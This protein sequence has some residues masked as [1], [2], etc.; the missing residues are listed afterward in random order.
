MHG[1]IHCRDCGISEVPRRRLERWQIETGKLL[2]AVYVCADCAIH[3][4]VPGQL[5]QVGKATWAGRPRDVWFG[6]GN[7]ADDI[8]IAVETLPRRPKAIVFTPTEHGAGRWQDEID[9][10]VIALESALSFDGREFRLDIEHVESRIID[11]GLG[12]EEETPERKP[13]KRAE[14]AA[15]IERIKN[16]L[17]AH[18]RSARDHAFATKDQSGEPQ[19]L[20][21]PTQKELAGRVRLTEPDVSR[22]LK[23]ESAR[24]LRIYWELA[25]NLDQIMAWKGPLNG[26]RKA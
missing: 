11:A 10:L 4:R 5:W 1:F 8:A 26:G 13:R 21:R 24:E 19:L 7:R 9:N 12:L 17:I 6:R 22:C 15:N 23:D 14:R 25:L 20:P 18:L 2:S 3:E 16:E